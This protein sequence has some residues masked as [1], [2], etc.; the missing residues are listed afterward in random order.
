MTMPSSPGRCLDEPRLVSQ[1]LLN[2][3]NHP[4]AS[5]SEFRDQSS[6]GHTWGTWIKILFSGLLLV[7]LGC[8]MQLVSGPWQQQED[9]QSGGSICHDPLGASPCPT[10]LVNT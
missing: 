4:K 6:R 3:K 1:L 7:A 9:P 2:G 5:C 10:I 8:F